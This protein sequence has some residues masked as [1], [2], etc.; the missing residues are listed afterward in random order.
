MLLSLNKKYLI[1]NH[2]LF[3]DPKSALP[4]IPIKPVKEVGV[5]SPSVKTPKEKTAFQTFVSEAFGKAKSSLGTPTNKDAP[6]VS[7]PTPN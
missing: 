3:Q 2:F 5:P 4:T 6:K 7:K 1:K